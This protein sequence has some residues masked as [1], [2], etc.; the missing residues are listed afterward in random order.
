MQIKPKTDDSLVLR[1]DFSDDNAWSKICGLITTPQTSFN[2]V[3]QVEFY[4]DSTFS[5]ATAQQIVAG[6]PTNRTHW[7]LLVVDNITR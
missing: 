1:T 3:A 2:F 6:L 4:S 5:Q 7:F